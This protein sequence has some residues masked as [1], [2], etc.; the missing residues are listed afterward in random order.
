MKFLHTADWQIG[1]KCFAA[2]D[3]ADE[4][5]AERLKTVDR[6]I[7]LANARAVD[8][9]LVAGDVFDN[10]T[11]K[12]GE[13]G[14][15][16]AALKRAEMPVF[17]LP[18][19]HDP[20]G[21]RGPYASAAWLT[22]AGSRVTTILAKGSYDVTGGVLLATP[23]EAKYGT[24]DP[25]A[26]FRDHESPA[27][28]IRIGLAH[29]SLQLGEIAKSV[30]G[31]QRGNFPIALDAATRGR[32][33]YLALG[34]WHGFFTLPDGNARISYSGAPEQTKFGETESGTVSIVS[35][36]AP[37]ETPV[38]ERVQVGKLRWISQEFEVSDDASIGLL[39]ASLRA[40][41]KPE[42]TLVRAKARG[43]CTPAAAQQLA[44]LEPVFRAR[45]FFFEMQHEYAARPE[46][47]EAWRQL[48]PPGD[49]R[50]L[51]DELL[52]R[53]DNRDRADVARRALD[54]LAECAR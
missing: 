36:E 19:N 43:L 34:D 48:M 13:V 6:I 4:V 15:V 11:P 29:G 52:R 16:V 30:T 17:V 44:A 21:A 31:D 47:S 25:T 27:G 39:D 38:I 2:G 42:R 8:F 10:P 40:R 49:L 7:D 45:F 26:E 9:M 22:L 51:V 46:T 14:T 18:G 54:L 28:A 3:R 37:G 5:R 33:D 1:M 20:V 23:C 12:A 35:I 32:L 41:D 53:I 50:P 24:E